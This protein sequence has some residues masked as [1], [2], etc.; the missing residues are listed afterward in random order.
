MKE[1]YS[2]M[3]RIIFIPIRLDPAHVTDSGIIVTPWCGIIVVS[4]CSI[5]ASID[6]SFSLAWFDV[7]NELE[8]NTKTCVIKY[9]ILYLCH[10][11]KFKYVN[12]CTLLLVKSLDQNV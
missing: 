10:W 9:D 5:L 4:L 11:I 3:K 12:S 7:S 8:D 2:I 6:V 1:D